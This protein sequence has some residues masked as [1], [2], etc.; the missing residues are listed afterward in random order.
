MSSSLPQPQQTITKSPQ[1]QDNKNNCIV[2]AD[3]NTMVIQDSLVYPQQ[4]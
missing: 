1:T 2:P 4:T 3:K